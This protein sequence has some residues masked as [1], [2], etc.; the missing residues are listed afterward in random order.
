VGGIGFFRD[1][2]GLIHTIPDSDI[3]G[4]GR[5]ISEPPESLQEAMRLFFLGVAAWLTQGAVGHRSMM[6]HPSQQRQL[7]A[8]YIQWAEDVRDRWIR[9][10]ALSADDPDRQDLLAEFETSYDSLAA[11][12]PDI[13]TFDLVAGLLIAALRMTAVEE[14]NT[15]TGPTPIIDWNSSYSH[16]LVGGEVLSRGYTVEGLTV[17]YMPRGMGVG[18]ADT[19]Q[20]RARFLGYK[21]SYLGYCRVFLESDAREA[22][23]EYVE[24]EE[25]VR[26]Q[27]VEHSNHGGSLADWKRALILTIALRPTRDNVI[28]I[29][30]SQGRFSDEWYVPRSPHESSD[31]VTS[32][33]D[34]VDDLIAASQFNEDSG[35]PRRTVDQRHLVVSDVP[36][37]V[38]LDRLLTQFRMTDPHDSRGFTLLRVQVERYVRQH[39]NASCAIYRMSGGRTRQRGVRSGRIVNLFQGRNPLNGPAIY[40]GDAAIRASRGLSIQ[41]HTLDL[42]DADERARIA[43]NVPVLAVW[44]PSEMAQGV[45]VQDQGGTR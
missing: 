2:P 45:L 42:H 30:Y 38:V 39:P 26:Q 29:G 25:D 43:Q 15:R 21:Q 36:L 5:Q 18:N 23:R 13:P 40:P 6:V 37:R 10:L 17:T 7:H 41:V 1:N 27:L 32:N 19:I 4:R 33:R 24:H 44:V 3:I 8:Q 20:Q 14:V 22:F 9:T 35:D 12:V 34:T 28:D 16:I 31:A 11:T